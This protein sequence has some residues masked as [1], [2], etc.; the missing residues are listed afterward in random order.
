MWGGCLHPAPPHRL[1]PPWGW[2]WGRCWGL[3]RCRGGWEGGGKCQNGA[4][5]TRA[6]GPWVPC[7]GHTPPAPGGDHG[8]VTAQEE[9][10]PTAMAQVRDGTTLGPPPP[11]PGD[12]PGGQPGPTAWAG[13]GEMG[14]KWGSGDGGVMGSGA[15]GACCAGVCVRVCNKV[16]MCAHRSV[17]VCVRQGVH[18]AALVRVGAHGCARVCVGAR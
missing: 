17:R 16:G 4:A 15:G 8:W 13:G 1:V 9:P 11:P 3:K 10:C 7:S 12:T 2:I 14:Q 5:P 18:V 6:G